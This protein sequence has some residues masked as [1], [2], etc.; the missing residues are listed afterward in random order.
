MLNSEIKKL[1]TELT[2]L[3]Y[4]ITQNKRDKIRGKLRDEKYQKLKKIGINFNYKIRQCTPMVK[5]KYKPFSY[6]YKKFVQFKK[7]KGHCCIPARKYRACKADRDF[8]GYVILLRLKKRNGTL[9]DWQLKKLKK[10][11]FV[12]EKTGVFRW[13]LTFNTLKKTVREGGFAKATQNLKLKEWCTFWK[14]RDKKLIRK[15]YVDCLN[16]INFPWTGKLSSDAMTF[17]RSG[18]L[19]WKQYFYSM[20]KFIKRNG[21]SYPTLTQ[22]WSL[23]K[24][25]WWQRNNYAKGLLKKK[26]IRLLESIGFKWEPQI[27]NREKLWN[28]KWDLMFK[29]LVIFKNK[30]NT[31][32]VRMKD[33]PSLSLWSSSQRHAY[34]VGLLKKDREKRL[35]SIGFPF[36]IKKSLAIPKNKVA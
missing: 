26:V 32:H 14:R 17:S 21:H 6:Y 10:I 5:T 8:Y 19:S 1:L 23:G 25:A 3:N 34:K 24:W 27:K 11:G 4:W 35:I 7:R 28:R 30:N 16:S 13:M 33:A 15:E 20:K 9:P 18:D 36:S 22:K 31:L 2:G 12:F 29:K